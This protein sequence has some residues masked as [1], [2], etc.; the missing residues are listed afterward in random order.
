MKVVSP[1]CKWSKTDD[2]GPER[3]RLCVNEGKPKLTKS[4]M[5]RKSSGL[6]EPK[7]EDANPTRSKPCGS[8]TGPKRPKSEADKGKPKHAKL[9]AKAARPS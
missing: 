6:N 8:K 3:P 9:R 4:K 2:K 7:T 5:D 1:E